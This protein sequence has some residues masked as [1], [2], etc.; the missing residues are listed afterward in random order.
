MYKLIIIALG[1]LLFVTTI[2]ANDVSPAEELTFLLEDMHTF[3]ADFTQSSFDGSGSPINEVHGDMVVQRPGRLYWHTMG[4]FEQLL[5][6]DGH[7]LWIYDPELE[8]VVVQEFDARLSQTPALLLSG[9]I[10]SLNSAFEVFILPS[11]RDNKV[12]KL[13]PIQADSLFEHLTLYFK[14]RNLIQMDI[15]DALGQNSII[16]FSNVHKNPE[17][18]TD[19]FIFIP[20][21]GVDV[22]NGQ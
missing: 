11:E 17:I 7:Q 3:A 12:F 13:T 15:T 18:S 4:A 1:A 9:E 19:K 16:S 10:A 5:V 14:N 22:I 2:E 8:Q 6:A 20:P 21:S